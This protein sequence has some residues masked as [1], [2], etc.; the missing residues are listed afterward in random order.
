[1]LNW[2][3]EQPAARRKACQDWWV[4]AIGNN[5]KRKAW[6]LGLPEADQ[7]TVVDDPE[8]CPRALPRP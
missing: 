8:S 5:P 2:Y 1:V 3:F 6:F 4:K 7:L